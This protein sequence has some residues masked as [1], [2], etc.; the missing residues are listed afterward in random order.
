MDDAA[1]ASFGS[2]GMAASVGVGRICGAGGHRSAALFVG[3]GEGVW[4]SCIST[5][6]VIDTSGWSE[7][8]DLSFDGLS[9]EGEAA[10]AGAKVAGA[11]SILLWLGV[12]A[13]GRFIGFT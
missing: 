3:S 13:A 7:R 4:Q 11:V 6:D 2:G 12:V 10:P 8:A 5:E 1:G 9:D